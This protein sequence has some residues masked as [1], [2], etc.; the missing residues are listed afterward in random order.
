MWQLL[1]KIQ[2]GVTGLLLALSIWCAANLHGGGCQRQN[3]PCPY[4]GRNLLRGL[5]WLR[6]K[7]EQ[8]WLLTRKALPAPALPLLQRTDSLAQ[9]RKQKANA[10]A[11]LGQERRHVVV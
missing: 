9:V 8:S 7:G 5:G 2:H 4:S 10:K 1:H 6:N 3:G 11:P